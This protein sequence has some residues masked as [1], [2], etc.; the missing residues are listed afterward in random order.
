MKLKKVPETMKPHVA[1][2]L[3]GE[4]DVPLGFGPGITILDIGANVGAF[5]VWAAKRW[6]GCVTAI[7]P[8]REN[9][10]MLEI[11]TA[12]LGGR[13]NLINAAVRSNV[14]NKIM[15]VGK[16]NCGEYSF[17]KGQ[18]QTEEVVEVDV[19]STASL[20]LNS[21]IIKVDTEG[22]EVEIIRDLLQLGA[23]PIIFL[24]E[25]HSEADRRTIDEL[26][27]PLYV[28]WGSAS[29]RPDFGVV[30]YVSKMVDYRTPGWKSMST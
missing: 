29:D 23:R 11:N 5:T 26:L 21:H 18:S 3:D 17:F 16:N 27:N 28:M 15:Y 9:F 14:D 22:C 7:E 13:V 19:M 24:A 25:Y 12:E 2:V 4:Y 8:I 30:K 1:K 10:E 6:G 20:P